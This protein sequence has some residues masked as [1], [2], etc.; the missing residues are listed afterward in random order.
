MAEYTTVMNSA[1][2]GPS[3][4]PPARRIDRLPLDAAAVP[5]IA[6]LLGGDARLAAFRLKDAEV[7]QIVVPAGDDRGPTTLTLWPSLRRVDAMAPG[8]AVVFTDVAGV[9]LVEGVEA[10]FRRTNG[11]FL[12][13]AIGGKVMVRA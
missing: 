13:V 11:E 10:L 12:I 7:Y 2:P 5:A 6:A 4:T 3:G 8:V 1:D 9:E